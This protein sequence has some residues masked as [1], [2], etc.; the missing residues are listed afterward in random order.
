M[1]ISNLH[2]DRSVWPV[3]PRRR[4]QVPGAHDPPPLRC[5]TTAT[6]PEDYRH[7]SVLPECRRIVGHRRRYRVHGRV[8][9]SSRRA[10]PRP[11]RSPIRTH[12]R[13]DVPMSVSTELPRVASREEWLAARLELL[14]KE[15]ELTRA[16]DALS[17]E[18]RRL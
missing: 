5:I 7:V 18:R 13:G 16:R 9:R 17:A 14:N 3:Y 1:A 4:H 10:S 8:G 11:Q 12:Y 6:R 2:T 15:K